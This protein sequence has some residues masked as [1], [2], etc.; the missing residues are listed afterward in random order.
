[1]TGPVWRIWYSD[2]TTVSG[3][4]APPDDV[5]GYGVEAIAQPDPTPGV[6]NVGYRRLGGFDW[7]YWRVDDQEWAGAMGDASIWDL[8]LH[9]EPIACVCQGRRISDV[10]YK[11]I[12]DEAAEWARQMGLPA[13][14]GVRPGVEQG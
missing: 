3:Q 14:S 4:G 1:M 8:I 7:Y 6:G 13:K 2:G 12:L 11:A 5:P 9:R 10:R